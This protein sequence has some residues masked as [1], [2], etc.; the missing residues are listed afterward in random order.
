V[1]SREYQPTQTIQNETLPCCN[2]RVRLVIPISE[3]LA[4][5]ERVCP[6][7]GMLWTFASEVSITPAEELRETQTSGYGVTLAFVEG[8][9]EAPV[10]PESVTRANGWLDTTVTNLHAKELEIKERRRAER[11]RERDAGS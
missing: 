3:G 4:L 1:A 7:C 6:E 2:K 5:H 8:R 11:R 10:T 9:P